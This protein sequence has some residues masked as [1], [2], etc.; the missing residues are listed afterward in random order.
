MP[1]AALPDKSNLSS[2][3]PATAHAADATATVARAVASMIAGA[4]LDERGGGT[5][6]ASDTI[7]NPIGI[8][9]SAACAAARRASTICRNSSPRAA[10]SPAF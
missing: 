8:A 6:P 2:I 9:G 3:L 7:G 1:C 4:E 5:G 10:Y